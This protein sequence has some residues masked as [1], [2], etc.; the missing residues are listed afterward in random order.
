VGGDK[1]LT[2]ETTMN[3]HKELIKALN[4]AA[5]ASMDRTNRLKAY[6]G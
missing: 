2:K 1:Q 6:K 5:K 3:N 4:A